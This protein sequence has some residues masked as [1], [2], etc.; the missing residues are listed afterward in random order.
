MESLLKSLVE[1]VQGAYPEL[2]GRER[3][4]AELVLESPGD[5]CMYPASELA[6]LA[7]V[8]NSTVTRFVRRVGFD[9]YEE[10]RR[11]AIP[12]VVFPEA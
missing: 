2:S 6:R 1:S 5:I 4:V 11:S 7:G 3:R 9:S 10:M 8:S 12:S